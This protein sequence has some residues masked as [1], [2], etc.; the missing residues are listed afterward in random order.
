MGG[1][2]GKY[3]RNAG[4][5][6]IVALLQQIYD[7]AQA[8]AKQTAADEKFEEENYETFVDTSKEATR[9]KH[10]GL[11]D[12]GEDKA[13]AEQDLQQAKSDMQ[14]SEESS[15]TLKSTAVALHGSCDFLLKNWDVR[16]EAR[17]D[18]VGALREAKAILSGM[19][20]DDGS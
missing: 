4:G 15:E 18:E 5:R 14:N 11:V 8:T 19:D 3:K 12:K 20:V 13:K 2:A 10:D 17:S 16:Q 9:T 7:E 6:T 1:F